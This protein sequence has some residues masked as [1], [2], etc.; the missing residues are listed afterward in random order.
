MAMLILWFLFSFKEC[1]V[2]CTAPTQTQ[3]YD[4]LW[5]ELQKWILKMPE[6]AKVFYEYTSDY[7]RMSERPDTWFARARTGRKE[8]PE[9]LAG[10]HAEFMML[11]VDEASGVPD[12]I[13]NSSKSALTGADTL[14]LMISNYTRLEGYF[15]ES[16]TILI[17]LLTSLLYRKVAIFQVRM[18]RNAIF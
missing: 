1:K 14:F 10:L 13:F 11:V 7:V 6:A 18:P 5:A 8:N 17:P 4:V 12:A 15:H 9:A 16:Q 2:P 3:M